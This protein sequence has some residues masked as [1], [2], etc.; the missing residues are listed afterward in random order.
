MTADDP[1]IDNDC[2]GPVVVSSLGD[3]LRSCDPS[4]LAYPP[5]AVQDV[6]VAALDWFVVEAPV[7]AAE[8]CA[9][10]TDFPVPHMAP[11]RVTLER[12]LRPLT[13]RS[14]VT[15]LRRAQQACVQP[16]IDAANAL[17]KPQRRRA[18]GWDVGGPIEVDRRHL[19]GLLDDFVFARAWCIRLGTKV[20]YWSYLWVG[21]CM[22]MCAVSSELDRA[23]LADALKDSAELRFS[24][25]MAAPAE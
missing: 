6:I 8:H 13:L 4:A 15:P 5:P 21:D 10:A 19:G 12:A 9:D 2:I 25:A 16:Y 20:G 7:I 23:Q 11:P 17:P 24:E 22:R 1:N 14:N 3:V 18:L